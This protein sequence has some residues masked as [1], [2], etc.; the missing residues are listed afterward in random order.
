M[1]LYAAWHEPYN[2]DMHADVFD[3]TDIDLAGSREQVLVGGR[4][5]FPLLPRALDGVRRIG[6][7]GWG[8]QAEAQ[9]QNLRD[10]LAGTGITVTV[11]LRRESPSWA[12]AERAGFN[13]ADGTLGPLAD[14]VAASDLNLLLISDAALAARHEELFAL[15]RPGTTIGLSHG[16]LLAH[17][18]ATGQSMPDHVSVIAVC[19]KGMGKSVRRLY[20]Q[21]TELDGAG[22]NASIA[23]H[24]DL[25]GR[26]TDRAL[27]WAVAIGAP[28]VFETTLESEY[29]S[30]IAGERAILLA[31]PHAIAE[32][33][34]RRGIEHGDSPTHAFTRSSLSLTGPLARAISSGGIA[35][36]IDRFAGDDRRSFEEAYC[37][38]YPAMA[39]IVAEI[40]DDVESGAE[41]A[42]VERAARR[43]DEWPMSTIDGTR[44]W[45][46]GADLRN[47]GADPDVAIDPTTAGLFLA[48]M[49]AQV[50][51]L[52]RRGHAWSEIANESVIEVVDSLLPYMHA[53]GVAYMVDSCSTT[54]RLGARKWA[55]R[56]ESAITQQVLPALDA[57]PCRDAARLDALRSHAIHDVLRTI[58]AFRPSVDVAV[59]AA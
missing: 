44:M 2:G 40:Y 23:V 19:P 56:F 1:S 11:G 57:G 52:A 3:L 26:S 45:V 49:V 15:A 48:G 46:V 20:E 13:E 34:Y 22:I 25:D 43:L 18:Q 58:S 55:P 5:L 9:S 16:F 8:S 39:G 54:A 47:D 6:V 38:A 50:D 33:M 59:D 4:H 14:V 7:I 37:A 51:L 42:S 30:D 35:E 28:Y 29:L 41:V 21:G 32:A 24:Q 31:I 36:V 17:L 27:A 12:A 10:S 53:R